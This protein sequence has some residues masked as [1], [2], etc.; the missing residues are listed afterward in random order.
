[1]LNAKN[2]PQYRNGGAPSRPLRFTRPA[3]GTRGRGGDRAMTRR[4]EL[5]PAGASRGRTLY[6]VLADGVQVGT[7]A[8]QDVDRAAPWRLTV[9]GRCA[10]LPRSGRRVVLATVARLLNGPPGG[11]TVVYVPAAPGDP[12]EGLAAD[13]RAAGFEIRPA[14][15][16]GAARPLPPIPVLREGEACMARQPDPDPV[17]PHD[18]RERPCLSCHRPFASAGPG[19]RVCRKCKRQ[20]AWKSGVGDFVVQA[21]SWPGGPP[22]RA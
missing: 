18:V 2:T 6:C 8:E 5:V 10:D 1:M 12:W 3:R 7:A 16:P 15:M 20:D 19:N 13:L 9:P 4:I 11:P 17:A 21:S 22:W 14:P